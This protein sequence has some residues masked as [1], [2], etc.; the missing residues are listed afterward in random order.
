MSNPSDK[1]REIILGSGTDVPYFTVA[2]ASQAVE[3]TGLDI[4]AIL[5]GAIIGYYNQFQGG[6]AVRII[7]YGLNLPEK[8]ALA[9]VLSNDSGASAAV[10]AMSILANFLMSGGAT[11]ITP[12]QGFPIL[13]ENVYHESDYL[14]LPNA[15]LP[16]GVPITSNWQLE[17]SFT[18]IWISMLN[19]PSTY[20]GKMFYIRPWVEIVHT[21]PLVPGPPET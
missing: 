12:D 18:D 19:V 10:P 9:D 1:I 17:V 21:L 4:W 5:G 20:N 3:C 13:R 8:F 2:T 16:V 7:G 11:D 15:I 6:D 14:L